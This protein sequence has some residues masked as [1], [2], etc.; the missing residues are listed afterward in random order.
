MESNLGL[1]M[2]HRWVPKMGP[3]MVLMMEILRAYCLYIH[4]DI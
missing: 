3:L 4:W 2:E 1:M